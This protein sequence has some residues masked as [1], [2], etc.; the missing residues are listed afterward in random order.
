MGAYLYDYAFVAIPT[1]IIQRYQG[2]VEE[3]DLIEYIHW[4]LL[5]LAH[6]GVAVLPLLYFKYESKKMLIFVPLFYLV[7]QLLILTFI[8]L[9]L[10][11]FAI[12]W[13]VVLFL[14]PRAT[15]GNPV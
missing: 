12:V 13:V 1:L 5:V 3:L 4:M 2:I 9:V 11:P 10:V 8:G 6:I 14:A 15:K 7:L